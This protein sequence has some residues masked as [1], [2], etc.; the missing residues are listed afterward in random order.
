MGPVFAAPALVAAVPEGPGRDWLLARDV[1]PRRTDR[2]GVHRHAADRSGEVRACYACPG[3]ALLGPT[4]A[5]HGRRN[6]TAA[7]HPGRRALP[8]VRLVHSPL[9]RERA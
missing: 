2:V 4:S 7:W 9:N 8:A 6:G 1:L 3:L 5:R